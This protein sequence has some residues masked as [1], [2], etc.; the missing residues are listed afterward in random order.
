MYGLLAAELSRNMTGSDGELPAI[1]ARYQGYFKEPRTLDTAGLF[2]AANLCIQQ[3]FF[4]DDD[5][6]A[7]S[8]ESFKQH[9]AKDPAWHWEDRGWYVH[10]T[11]SGA[12]GRRIEIYANAPRPILSTDSDNPRHALMKMMNAEG[13]APR[14]DTS[15][16]HLVRG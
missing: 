14:R 6:G 13:L 8:F 12:S 3:Q 10:V 5:D 9:Y 11:G 7:D 2:N 4:Y 15:R 1:A 16:T